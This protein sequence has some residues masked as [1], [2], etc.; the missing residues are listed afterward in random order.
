MRLAAIGTWL[1]CIGLAAA[2]AGASEPPQRTVV[3]ILFDG[4]LPALLDAHPTPAFDR[5]E[6]EGSFSRDLAPVF[7]SISLAN[8]T[9][10]STG[11]WPAHHGIVSNEFLDPEL[12]RYDH[13]LGA[14]WMT[15]CE[16]LH[17]AAKRQGLRSAALWY[18]GTHSKKNGPQATYV[19]PDVVHEQRPP[20]A[21]R[22]AELL[23]L[24]ALPDA[25]RP[26]FVA[27]YM[28]GPDTPEHYQGIDS[29]E[30]AA[31]VV[32][33]D[34]L[35]GKILAAIDASPAR[36]RIA[37]LVTTDHGMRAVDTIVNMRRILR[38]HGIAATPISSG[39]TSFV[40]L[41]KDEPAEMERAAAALSGYPEFEVLR[42]GAFPEYAQLGD[43]PRVPALIV[44]A[45]PPYFIENLERW[46][47]WLQWV[48]DYGPEFLYAGFNL[49]ATHGFPPDTEGMQGILYA[50]GSGV[51]RGQKLGPVR[52]I[53]IH[54]TV[55]RLL[56][57][58]PGR[59]VDGVVIEGLI[60]PPRRALARSAFDQPASLSHGIVWRARRHP[61]GSIC[62][63]SVASPCS[64]RWRSETAPKRSRRI[65]S[66]VTG[67]STT[68]ASAVHCPITASASDSTSPASAT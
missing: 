24:L 38:N 46:P 62:E 19:S 25:E 2:A 40:Y 20:D 49:K 26:A 58:E 23:R 63:R 37:V 53:D 11:C 44:S 39:T 8:Q 32:E 10:I 15:G 5:I 35:V 17:Q 18:P 59:A 42:R 54:P 3:L 48:G 12:G 52:A 55:A 57:M 68:S 34:A 43:G 36:D 33:A 66:S 65:S 56:G 6:R 41:E 30:T 13:D 64:S 51:A 4:F 29:P 28:N 21:Q 50:W 45:K 14:D 27:L 47:S 16:H 22:V 9:S 60:A 67:A 31:A 61:C 7:P 1:V